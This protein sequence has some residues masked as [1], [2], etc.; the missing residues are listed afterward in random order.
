LPQLRFRLP[1]LVPGVKTGQG[2]DVHRLSVTFCAT[3]APGRLLRRRPSSPASERARIS[4]GSLLSRPAPGRQRG[5]SIGAEATRANAL[6]VGC[7][8]RGFPP[9]GPPCER[10]SGK[11]SK[12]GTPR[13]AHLALKRSAPAFF[14]SPHSL[15][16][17]PHRHGCAGG[18]L[19][20]SF[21]YLPG[22]VGVSVTPS[23]RHFVT[24][25]P[26]GWAGG[27]RSLTS[28]RDARYITCGAGA[29][30]GWELGQCLREARRSDGARRARGES[31]ESRNRYRER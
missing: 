15:H 12:H 14:G 24:P 3:P 22:W 16:L 6:P 1:D 13:R 28:H 29:S 26:G 20:S 30:A 7:Q 2:E 21:F 25:S 18:S 19:L 10:A 23:L 8:A 31:P 11:P 27:A 9:M 5:A 4:T 17:T